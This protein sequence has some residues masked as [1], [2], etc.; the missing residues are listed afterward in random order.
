MSR[1]HVV[2]LGQSGPQIAA[3]FGFEDWKT[4]YQHADNAELRE[5]RSDPSA[6][7]P[8][9]VVAIPPVEPRVF[10]LETGKRHR[11][12]IPRPRAT[13]NLVVKDCDAEPLAG[14]P[15][16]LRVAGRDEPIEGSTSG[17]GH[18]ECDLPAAAREAQLIVWA[19]GDKTG[20]RYV[21][22]LA[23]AGLC[24]PES[25]AGMR[26]RLC[27]LGY[28]AGT[29]RAETNAETNGEAKVDDGSAA[30][31]PDGAPAASPLRLAVAA[32]QEDMGLQVTGELDADTRSKVIAAHGGT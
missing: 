2:Q 27:N 22:R 6:V 11:I 7:F 30:R 26:Q 13:L 32:F 16:E 9:D 24:A 21:W 10:K 25:D 3:R 29:T 17:D 28:H 18:V 5:K 31:D 19:G 1:K 12:V 8:G 14:K 15:F 23:L 4:L 20:P